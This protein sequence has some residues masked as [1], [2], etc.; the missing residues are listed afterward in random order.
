[1]DSDVTEK[2]EKSQELWESVMTVFQPSPSSFSMF[3]EKSQEQQSQQKKEESHILQRNIHSWV[4]DETTQKCGE[5]LQEFTWFRRKHHCRACGRIFCYACTQHRIRLPRQFEKFPDSPEKWRIT[6]SIGYW[7]L[8]ENDIQER[9]CN[10]CYIKYSKMK[11]IW[12]NIQLLHILDLDLQDWSQ[13]SCLN[14][15]WHT[16]VIYCLSHFREIH[17]ALPSHSF[18][19]IE[20]NGYGIIKIYLVDMANGCYHC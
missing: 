18:T 19:S 16:S 17:Y 1:M 8:G 3:I 15:D 14:H 5:C 13:I 6:Q 4:N 11:K 2:I 7:V 10:K 12:I 20:K 9:V